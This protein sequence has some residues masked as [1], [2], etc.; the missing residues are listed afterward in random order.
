MKFVIIVL[1]GLL[2]ISNVFG[3]DTN[4][5]SGKG[6]TA[7]A[8]KR[9]SEI[10]TKNIIRKKCIDKYGIELNQKTGELRK[11][12][13]VYF[14]Q[15]QEILQDNYSKDPEF[16]SIH[17]EMSN[18]K[19]AS[20]SAGASAKAEMVSRMKSLQL[21]RNAAERRIQSDPKLVVIRKKMANTSHQIDT[22]IREITKEDSE[23]EECLLKVNGGRA[24]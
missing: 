19:K 2:P 18:V 22:V 3:K 24:E 23:C 5:Y 20:P 21:R 1:A 9:I 15:E 4:F 17:A 12:I 11:Q 14:Q 16:K 7:S 13:Q 8:E 10:Q 6:H